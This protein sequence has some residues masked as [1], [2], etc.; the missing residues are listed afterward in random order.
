MTASIY[1]QSIDKQRVIITGGQSGLITNMVRHVLTS[2]QR[3]YDFFSDGQLESF[4][5]DAPVLIIEAQHQLADYHHHILLLTDN[6]TGELKELEKIA[7]ATP[8]GG[9]IIYPELNKELK[10]LATRERPDVQVI[11]YNIYKH[12]K[13][14]NKTILI[15]S[16]NEKF[17]IALNTTNE[18]ACVGAA[19]ELLKKIGI[20]SGQF[21]RAVSTFQS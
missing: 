5:T 11:P 10:A 20:S 12:E 16:T 15:T 14:Q 17:P 7:D 1:Q 19:R 2:N 8:K 6:P 4:L 18:L 9:I 21:Y 13:Q 3:K